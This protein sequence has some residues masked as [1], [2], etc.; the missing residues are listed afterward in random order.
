MQRLLNPNE[1]AKINERLN[2]NALLQVCRKVWPERQE[3]I[4]SVMVRSEDIFMEV[5]WLMDELID[6]ENDADINTLIRGLWSTV[7]LDIG[8][9]ASNVSK[10]DRYLIASTVFRIAATAFSL[11]WH[12]YYCDTLRDAL[13]M[14]TDERCPAPEDLYAQQQQERQQQEL[15]EAIIP[16]SGILNDW[17][18]EYIDNTDDCLADEI[19]TVLKGE[20]LF[21]SCVTNPQKASV[22]IRRIHDYMEGKSKP[23]DVMMPIRAAMDAGAIRRPTD[24]EFY[25]EFGSDR[26]KG[27]SSFNDYTNPDKAPYRGADFEAMKTEF[28]RLNEE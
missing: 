22:I 13:L 8:H 28:R 12:S 21:A 15:L 3:E 19:E 2:D 23:K 27:K 26:V 6:V 10:P 11:H 1:A 18:N 5:A 16:C 9:W 7:I 20:R 4:T 24:E 25:N 14:V 17:V